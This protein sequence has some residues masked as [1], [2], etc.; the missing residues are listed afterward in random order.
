MTHQVHHCN[1]SFEWTWR[2]NQKHI[3]AKQILKQI[4]WIWTMNKTIYGDQV[5]RFHINSQYPLEIVKIH[6]PEMNNMENLKRNDDTS[7]WQ[8]FLQRKFKKLT[9]FKNMFKNI[10]PLPTSTESQLSQIHVQKFGPAHK[11][12]IQ[13]TEISLN[14]QNFNW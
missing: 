10:C 14:R 1:I 4:H 8:N 7:L 6:N 11:Q 9:M 3:L 13:I 5:K 2:T 12:I